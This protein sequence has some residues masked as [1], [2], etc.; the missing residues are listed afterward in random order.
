MVRH[1]AFLMNIH[2]K[3]VDGMTP[4][5]RVRG[6]PFNMRTLGF[7]EYVHYKY[8]GKGPQHNPH[9]NASDRWGDGIFLGYASQSNSYFVATSE[10]VVT[11]RAVERR[12]DQHKWHVGRLCSLQ[13][14]PWT[15]REKA[16]VEVTFREP[17]QQEEPQARDA[18]EKV[19]DFRI[20]RSD[21]E[22]F[23]YTEGCEMCSHT[24]ETGRGKPGG[25]H[26]PTCRARIM[27]ELGKTVMGQQRLSEHELKVDDALADYVERHTAEETRAAVADLAAPPPRR[28]LPDPTA[29]R[30]EEA[31][32]TVVPE[33]PATPAT[34]APRTEPTPR[35]AD[36]EESDADEAMGEGGEAS[37]DMEIGLMDADGIDANH[38]ASG[39]GL[40]LPAD[41]PAEAKREQSTGTA[42]DE[43]TAGDLVNMLD[44]GIPGGVTPM[45]EQA[46]HD[47]ELYSLIAN[48]GVTYSK[49]YQRERRSGFRKIVTEVYSPPRVAA[50]AAEMPSLGILP[51]YSFDIRCNDPDDGLPWD[52]SLNAKRD[53]A[54]RLVREQRPLFVIGSPCCTNY[55][56]W[57]HLNKLKWDAETIRRRDIAGS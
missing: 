8:P 12:P 4:W 44:S 29:T 45:L 50:L 5:T 24:L 54:L 27:A 36:M 16:D 38:A 14:T 11:S 19:K 10:G 6:R 32:A 13:S 42:P 18:V 40:L 43:M 51:G 39:T 25:R 47:R 7:G 37:P 57:Q 23:G 31:P 35:W 15:M 49:K 28:L 22:R 9:G 55:C 3:G 52:L 20:N 1:S 33:G 30:Q 34:A 21:L 2:M 26:T 56:S 46:E 41:E 48:L 53:K 17:A